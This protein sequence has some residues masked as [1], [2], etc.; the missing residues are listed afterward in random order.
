MPSPAS[1]TLPTSTA[2]MVV[3][4]CSICS[5]MMEAISSGLTAMVFSFCAAPGR[6]YAAGRPD[7]TRLCLCGFQVAFPFAY[8]LRVLL[9]VVV[10]I[11]TKAHEHGPALDFLL[12]HLR[13]QG[14]KRALRRLEAI[15]PLLLHFFERFAFTGGRF[16][17]VPVVGD[18]LT[19]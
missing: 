19:A 7:E 15:F 14:L 17:G 12:K 10:G 16:A 4:N 11:F 18:V 8:L 9:V 6:I 3:P 13:R 5:R 1:T 2:V